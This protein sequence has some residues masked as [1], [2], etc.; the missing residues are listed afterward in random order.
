M[1]SEDCKKRV[2][3][4]DTS[5]EIAGPGRVSHP[6]VGTCRRMQVKHRSNQHNVM[7]EAVQNHMPEVIVVDE[8]GEI[9]S[10]LFYTLY[11]NEGKEEECEAVRS[12]SQRGVQVLATTH[13]YNLEGMIKDRILRE[14]IGG[15]NDVVISDINARE[16]KSKKK[17]RL[18]R[19]DASCFDVIVEM[20]TKSQWRIHYDAN[21]AVDAILSDSEPDAEIR[22]LDAHGNIVVKRNEEEHQ[23][24]PSFENTIPAYANLGN[25]PGWNSEPQFF[26][27]WDMGPNPILNAAPLVP[28]TTVMPFVPEANETANTMQALTLDETNRLLNPPLQLNVLQVILSSQHHC[29]ILSFVVFFALKSKLTLYCWFS[30]AENNVSN[31]KL[32]GGFTNTFEEDVWTDCNDEQLQEATIPVQQTYSQIPVAQEWTVQETVRQAR[33]Q[34]AARILNAS[35]HYEVLKANANASKK[36]LKKCFTAVSEIVVRIDDE[37]GIMQKARTRLERA[38]RETSVLWE[39]KRKERREK[40]KARRDQASKQAVDLTEARRIMNA[41]SDLEVLK[42]NEGSSIDELKQ[43]MQ[44]MYSKVKKTNNEDDIVK[45]ARSRVQAAYLHLRNSAL[46]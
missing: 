5:N 33:L 41:S 6:A 38:F 23:N 20:A 12:I 21:S 19:V 2:M 26:D 11:V 45:E 43:H 42:A 31:E 46:Q 44:A 32:G 28:F 30:Q 37:D 8:I 4:V 36:M 18:E 35:T 13:G 1:L 3:I 10:P 22:Y 7:I 9:N 16:R 25:E 40:K 39:M 27:D 15:I 24:L 34:E 17:T 29:C 14:L